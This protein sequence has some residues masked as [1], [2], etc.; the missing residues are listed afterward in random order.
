MLTSVVQEVPITMPLGML[1]TEAQGMFIP[2]VQG[3]RTTIQ[4]GV[5]IK[6]LQ[7]N[8]VTMVHGIP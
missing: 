1:M 4:Q 3:V 7:E 8:E 2:M 6:A 5:R